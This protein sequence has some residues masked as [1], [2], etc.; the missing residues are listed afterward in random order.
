M[1]SPSEKMFTFC[2]L[3]IN[4]IS[5]CS[6]SDAFCHCCFNTFCRFN[7]VILAFNQ[8]S[9]IICICY[10][11]IFHVTFP[12]LVTISPTKHIL[13]IYSLC[14][15]NRPAD[16]IQPCLKPFWIVNHFLVPQKTCTWLLTLN[17]SLVLTPSDAWVFPHFLC[18]STTLYAA[19]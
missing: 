14:R 9:G 18:C 12:I 5:V 2:T 4:I 19:H 3:A 7:C 8:Y 11:V 1:S 13:I 16:Q 10:G 17:V 6:N 15:L